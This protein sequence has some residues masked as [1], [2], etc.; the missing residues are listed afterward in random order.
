MDFEKLMQWELFKKPNFWIEFYDLLPTAICIKEAKNF[1]YV[2]ANKAHTILTGKQKDEY[3]GKTVFDLFPKEQAEEYHKN[4]L[5]LLEMRKP[6]KIHER[7]SFR[8]QTFEVFETHKI[9]Y[10]NEETSEIDYI[11]DIS[12]NVTSQIHADEIIRET[13]SKYSKLFEYLPVGILVVRGSDF[14]ILEVNNALLQMFDLEFDNV[15][16]KNLYELKFID[17]ERIQ[18]YIQSARE[19]QTMETYDDTTT[20]PSGRKVEFIINIAYIHFFE[21]EPWI[22]LIVS[23]VTQLS[24]ANREITEALKREQEYSIM[25]NRFVS[26]VSHE[27]RTPLTGIMLSTELLQKYWENWSNEERNKHFDRIRNTIHSIIKL[28][29]NVITISKIDEDKFP[30]NPTKINLKKLIQDN[31]DKVLTSFNLQREFVFNFKIEQEEV[32]AD[33]TLLGLVMSNLL[34]NAIKY[35]PSEIPIFIDVNKINNQL[36]ISVRNY[37]L[38]IPP[39]DLKHLFKPFYRGKNI[40]ST[41]GYGLGLSIVQKCVE[42]HYGTISVVS[43]ESDGTIFTI[44]LP[45]K[46]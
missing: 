40:S 6:F 27:L 30:F 26:M 44:L 20:L 3:P 17:Q 11:I 23:D 2:F 33:E 36:S 13:E 25:K 46:Y 42:S 8:L 39:E 4:D 43:N 16:Y 31:I 7:V 28:M 45:L 19:F 34:S 1:T 38:P 24:I 10:F 5:K 14:T 29:E 15:V 12:Q 37:G 18:R 32:I 22:V 21:Q 41:T 35:S 9:P